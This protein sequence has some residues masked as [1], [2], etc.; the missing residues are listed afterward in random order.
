MT[1]AFLWVVENGQTRQ[2]EIP[3]DQDL[4]VSPVEI[5]EGWEKLLPDS[6]VSDVLTDIVKSFIDRKRAVRMN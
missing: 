2:H 4:N 3:I 6:G 1:R 5:R